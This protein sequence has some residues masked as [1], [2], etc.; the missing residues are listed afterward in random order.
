MSTQA[1]TVER[2]AD[3]ARIVWD[4]TQGVML[5]PAPTG[6]ILVTGSGDAHIF[7]TVPAL[8]GDAAIRALVAE[9]LD[10]VGTC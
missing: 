3:G 4:G 9:L 10:M 2:R 5:T 6:L 7:D 8:L 1:P